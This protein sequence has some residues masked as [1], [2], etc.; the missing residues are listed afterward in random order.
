MPE[1]KMVTIDGIRVRAEDEARY[2]AR[3]GA[4][5]DAGPLTRAQADP[6]TQNP[7]EPG[8]GDEFDPAEHTV[9]QVVAYLAQADEQ[10]T[11]RVLDAEAA[12]EKRK[13]LLDRRDEFLA[14]A[15]AR[16]A[17]GGDGSGPAA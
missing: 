15:R 9:V 12:G 11:A 17:A 16:A 8:P 3:M 1:H 10:E 14:E 2:R 5:A 13:G 6:A 4:G 7:Q